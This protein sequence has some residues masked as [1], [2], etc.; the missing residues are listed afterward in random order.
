MNYNYFKSK[1]FLKFT[2]SYL[3][4]LLIPLIFVIVF[5]YRNATDNLQKEI[6]NAH[7]NQLTQIKTVVDGRM[8]DLRD[9]ASRMSY[10]ARLAHYRI[11][12]PYESRDAIAALDSYKSSNSIVED[13]FL[14]YHHDPNI[15]S[16]HGMYSLD[17]FR[18][19][20][21][22]GSWKNDELVTTLNSSKFPSIRLTNMLN[23]NSPLEQS[24]LTYILPI[25]PNTSDPY[26][27]VMYLIKEKEL[28][29]LIDSVLGN[30]RG[31]TYIF[32][33]HGRVL[34]YSGHGDTASQQDI[35]RLSELPPG[36]HNLSIN[37]EDHSVISV[38]SDVN[39]WSYVT[40]MA[41]NQFFSSVLNVRSFII[42]LF[43]VIAI[44][45]TAIALLFARMQYLPIAELVRFTNKKTD[46]PASGNE[47]EY[48]RTT[49]Q[50]YS[51]KVDLQEPYARNH[52]LSML[53]KH[54]H[55]QMMTHGIFDT[56]HLH[57]DQSHHFVMM[58]GWD[59]LEQQ[60]LQARQEV[61]RKLAFI[62]FPALATQ[63]YGVELPQLDQLALIV[64]LQLEDDEALAAQIVHIVDAIREYTLGI[65]DIHPMIGVGKCYES[66]QQLNQS[67]VE[68]CSAFELRKSTEHGTTVYFEKL[69]SAHDQ[70][71]LLPSNELLKLA[72]S[73][74]QGNYE[75]AKQIIHTAIYGLDNKQRS[76][77]LMRCVLFDLLNTM[78]KTAVELKMDNMMQSASPHFMNGPVHLIEQ[79]FYRLATQICTQV[80]QT[81]KKEEHSLMDHIVAFIDQHYVDHSLSL[82]S[83][84][85]AFTISPSHLSRSFKDKV[86]INF[87]QYIWQKRLDK[88]K[89]QLV[90]TS[91]PLKDIIQRVG[92]L[93]TPNFIRKFK[94]E[95]G[96]TPGQ[97]RQMNSNHPNSE[98][99]D[100]V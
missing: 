46:T 73:L 95:T 80:E 23:Q 45:G 91:D 83:V 99:N 66:P 7:F 20:Y 41:S 48:I 75:V 77:L 36:I 68:A 1:L 74:K 2:G 32:D 57:F 8:N 65:M 9:M 21:Q 50:Q 15:Y 92:Y 89:E 53:L 56:F 87:V 94:K 3:L 34:S 47:L 62:E 71:V 11:L 10:D 12:D 35:Q 27:S 79:N 39:G 63:V 29:Y 69:S 38:T 18:S 31:L 100:T 14:Y 60:H 86:G 96:Y 37:N 54:G 85:A 70:T 67:F 90:I 19:S 81:H 17:V 55:A 26:A 58:M 97:Y 6:E 52:V 25:I 82:E 42:I 59:D 93:D 33:N 88:V 51:S 78:L 4:I 76:I 64:S 13:I 22:F 44:V 84:S 43:I 30:Y 98:P 49:L 5:I 72:Q 24:V 28:A 61:H 16:N 40:L